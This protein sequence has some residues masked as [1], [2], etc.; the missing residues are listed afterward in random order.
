M[1]C[2]I[3]IL[4]LLACSALAYEN[5]TLNITAAGGRLSGGGYTNTGSIVPVGGQTS[6]A[7]TLSHQSG[8]AAGF[9]LQPET[10]FSGLADEWN[11]D[12]DQDGLYDSDEIVAGS[13]LWKSDTDGDGLSDPDEV[14]I[15]GTDPTL[16]D[17]DSDGMDDAHELVAGTSPTNQTSI[18]EVDCALLSDGRRQLSW[19][20]VTGRSYTFQYTDSLN[21]N[22]WQSYPLELNGADTI[23][24]LTDSE[25]ATNRFYRVRVRND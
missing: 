4:S 14:R 13:N 17:T 8:F 11:P 1:K 16:S 22:D 9:I 12:N 25:I 18:L 5:M 10:A 2:L 24:S 6:Q 7:G 15:H 20:G 23:L 19:F 3:F 21:A